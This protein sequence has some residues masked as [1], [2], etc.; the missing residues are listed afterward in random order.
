MLDELLSLLYNGV[1][2]FHGRLATGCSISAVA[3]VRALSARH[4]G[5]I[6]TGMAA[7]ARVVAT[8]TVSIVRRRPLQGLTVRIAIVG[9]HLVI[10]CGAA[11]LTVMQLL[12]SHAA[13]VAV[14]AGHGAWRLPVVAADALLVRAGCLRV[15]S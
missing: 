3:L 2:D 15:L 11:A 6:A 12:V 7:R 10:Y 1:V 14:R 4:A 5:T 9:V 13:S 8:V